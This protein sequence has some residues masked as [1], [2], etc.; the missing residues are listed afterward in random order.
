MITHKDS[1]QNK[2]K[3]LQKLIDELSELN[4]EGIN[5]RGGVIVDM[6]CNIIITSSLITDELQTNTLTT[7]S[8]TTDN[9]STNA[10]STNA[11]TINN[12]LTAKTITS[13]SITNSSTLKTNSLTVD[14][15]AT[16]SSLTV[17]NLK[18][19]NTCSL[20]T[21]IGCQDYPIYC[22]I[23]Y[24]NNSRFF[25]DTTATIIFGK[26]NN[27]VIVGNAT[28]TCIC[29][30]FFNITKEIAIINTGYVQLNFNNT[31]SRWL[32][33][34]YINVEGYRLRCIN[35]PNL[36]GTDN[37][38]ITTTG[39]DYVNGNIP[40][41]PPITGQCDLVY[42]NRKRY[43]NHPDTDEYTTYYLFPYGQKVTY[44]STAYNAYTV[45]YGNCNDL[46]T[47][48]SSIVV[49]LSNVIMKW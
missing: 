35:Y 9:L 25:Y 42:F 49:R 41:M 4:I 43:K 36:S 37:T 16:L 46:N 30:G 12:Q 19:T 33:L 29:W 20:T 11:L 34:L 38:V 3:N 45:R 47:N 26:Q 31:D 2:V 7:T 27:N 39:T 24:Q 14:N 6:T 13:E 22:H 10:L 23:L 5:I 18:V 40:T 17:S 8:L 32:T 21:S 1:L 44:N 15:S 48:L 28:N